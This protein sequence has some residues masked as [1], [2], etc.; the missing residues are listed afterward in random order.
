MNDVILSVDHLSFRYG[1]SEILSDVSF[2]VRRGDFV[3]LA[4]PNGAGKTTLMKLV[5]GLLDGYEGDIS[6]FGTPRSSFR[7]HRKVGYLPQRVNTFNPLF[8]ATAGE[9]VGLGLL[10]GKRLPKRLDGADRERVR[11]ALRSVDALD[12]EHSPI[13]SLSGGQQQRV[14]LARA[15]VS[16]PELLVLDEPVTALDPEARARFYAL[17]TR[18]RSEEGKTVVMITHDI[19]HAGEQGGTLLYLDKSVVF[20]GG[21]DEFCRS[22]SMEGKFGY[23]DQHVICHQH[24]T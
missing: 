2:C 17:L 20:F 8:P 7:D 14:F 10:S 3:A 24:T 16:D 13:G 1:A 4:G 9:V 5:L 6:L 21:F 22:K 23:F 15:L 12:L 11:E 18:L 19:P